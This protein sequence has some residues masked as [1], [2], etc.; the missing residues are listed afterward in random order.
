[1]K[2]HSTAGKW[3]EWACGGRCRI[4]DV[5][6]IVIRYTGDEASLLMELVV[7]YQKI[8]NVAIMPISLGI[9]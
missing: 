7:D 1:M 4:A 3:L 9:F 2:A 5:A 8:T 6:P